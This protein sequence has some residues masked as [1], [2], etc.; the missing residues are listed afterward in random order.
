MVKLILVL[1]PL[2]IV[3]ISASH[4][5]YPGTKTRPVLSDAEAAQ[6]TKAK[7][8]QGWNPGQIQHSKA[9]YTVGSGH[10]SHIQEAVNAAVK[11]R[12]FSKPTYKMF[13]WILVTIKLS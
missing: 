12:F 4:Q 1:L 3:A 13:V 9:D 11:V 2:W 6:Y 7:Y 10:Y 8:L 5:N